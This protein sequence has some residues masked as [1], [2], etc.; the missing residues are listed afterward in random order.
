MEDTGG[1]TMNKKKT[2][3]LV[4][5]AGKI[6]SFL[7]GTLQASNNAEVVLLG[8]GAHIEKT[9]TD[10]MVLNYKNERKVHVR[11]QVIENL[12][13]MQVE[14]DLILLTVRAYQTEDALED[15][16]RKIPKGTPILTFQNG[17]LI[18][19]ITRKIPKEDV[20][21]GTTIISAKIPSPGN[22][23]SA[24][25]QFPV[26]IGE[27]TGEK[28]LRIQRLQDAFE[29][30]GLKCSLS[31]N[32][33]GEIWGKLI[34]NSNSNTL[35][36]ATNSTI[37]EVFK[38]KK[39]REYSFWLV[40]EGF[41]VAEKEGIDFENIHSA[42]AKQLKVSTQSLEVYEE[43]AKTQYEKG[44]KLSMSTLIEAKIKTEVDYTNG[45]IASTGRKTG[46]RALHHEKIVEM[47][48]A[49]ELGLKKQS[50]DNLPDV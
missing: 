48:H 20:I 12:T 21:G 47:V 40:K 27:L 38:N 49:I 28:T 11:P 34:I 3:I 45:F 42:L 23:F 5:G 6:G 24:N 14:P 7:G 43:F 17:N 44:F 26:I 9:K 30:G 37:A 22:V 13:E 18:P 1:T 8:R 16:A 46:M 25:S 41:D 15:I 39:S 2:D 33:T 35:T 50:I 32:I 36:A 29:K 4:Y 31:E 19:T 10:G